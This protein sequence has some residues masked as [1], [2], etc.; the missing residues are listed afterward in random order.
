MPKTRAKLAT[1]RWGAQI[2][3]K[4]GREAYELFLLKVHGFLESEAEVEIVKEVVVIN[5]GS[6]VQS[7]QPA[8]NVVNEANNY[9]VSMQSSSVSSEPKPGVVKSSNATTKNG[10]RRPYRFFN[11]QELEMLNEG[12]FKVKFRHDL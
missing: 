5:V 4:R 11:S 3:K 7:L 1:E 2:L 9:G 6:G 8:S 12:G 10:G